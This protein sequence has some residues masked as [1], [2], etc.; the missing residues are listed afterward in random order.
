MKSQRFDLLSAAYFDNGLQS[1][2]QFVETFLH[3]LGR[4]TFVH[5]LW[6]LSPTR[7]CLLTFEQAHMKFSPVSVAI[8]EPTKVFLVTALLLLSA[9]WFLVPNRLSFVLHSQLLKL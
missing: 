2:R 8:Q 9:L 3:N 5:N 6:V 1:S 4:W 7:Q